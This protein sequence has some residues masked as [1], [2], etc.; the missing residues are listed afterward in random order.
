MVRKISHAS[1]GNIK[2]QTLKQVWMTPQYIDFRNRVRNIY[3]FALYTLRGCDMFIKVNKEDC[4]DNEFPVC[5]ACLWAQALYN[6][7]K[8][9]YYKKNQKKN[10]FVDFFIKIIYNRN[11]QRFINLFLSKKAKSYFYIKQV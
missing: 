11:R 8:Y 10:S 9:I 6:A 2:D 5:G 1:F 3:I 4:Y 7:L